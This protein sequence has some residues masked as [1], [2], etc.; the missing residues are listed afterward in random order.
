MKELE[1]QYDE[2][3]NIIRSMASTNTTSTNDHFL[4]PVQSASSS[5]S[6]QRVSSNVEFEIFARTEPRSSVL[7]EFSCLEVVQRMFIRT[8]ATIE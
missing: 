4:M 3:L 7:L 1:R 6:Q 5:N 8:K 2:K